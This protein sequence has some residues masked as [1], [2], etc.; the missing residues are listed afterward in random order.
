MKKGASQ[1]AS[2]EVN[3]QVPTGY[4]FGTELSDAEILVRVLDPDDDP[5]A[6][7][8]PLAEDSESEGDE[9]PLVT[10]TEE[11]ARQVRDPARFRRTILDTAR[12]SLLAYAGQYTAAAERLQRADRSRDL[13]AMPDAQTRPIENS[14]G[15][16]SVIEA[17]LPL[18]ELRV[19]VRS[20]VESEAL[21]AM[22]QG[23][24]ARY[25]EVRQRLEAEVAAEADKDEAPGSGQEPIAGDEREDDE[26]PG[27][28]S[29]LVLDED[30]R[31]IRGQ[32]TSGS[33]LEVLVS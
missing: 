19:R 17:E 23:D 32:T 10:W 31:A 4:V 2:L 14:L 16:F 11:G 18:G 13:P 27:A 6:W 22:R 7:S 8:G 9:G 28:G 29:R 12:A 30:E 24:E 21:A 26:P 1:V 20:G 33:Y 5:D 15:V 25:S 3:H